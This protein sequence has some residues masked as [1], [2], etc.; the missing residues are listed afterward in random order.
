VTRRGLAIAVVLLLTLTAVSGAQAA[1]PPTPS[2]LKVTLAPSY[3][4]TPDHGVTV[5]WDAPVGPWAFEVFRATDSAYSQRATV[6]SLS[7][8]TEFSDSAPDVA[9]G[10]RLCYQ[11]RSQDP[12][13]SSSPKTAPVCASSE[14]PLPQPNETKSTG[15]SWSSFLTRLQDGEVAAL[16]CGTHRGAVVVRRSNVTIQSAAPRCATVTGGQFSV[17]GANVTVQSLRFNQ[18]KVK[19]KDEHASGTGNRWLRNSFTNEFT[20]I[21][22]LLG[23]GAGVCTD[24]EVAD[25][26]FYRIGNPRESNIFDHAIYLQDTVRARVHHNT[27]RQVVG[28][29]AFH[30]YP[31]TRDGLFERNATWNSY[32]GVVAGSTTTNNLARRSAFANFRLNAR[33]HPT[34][35]ASSPVG[36]G[37]GVTDNVVWNADPDYPQD[38]IDPWS[39]TVAG[40]LVENPLFRNPPGGDMTVR[41]SALTFLPGQ[42]GARIGLVPVSST[43]P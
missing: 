37:N 33:R 41:E 20:G 31:N 30:A 25:N 28:G 39:L 17:E 42:P 6:P 4:D 13:G 29:Y 18:R 16:A 5:A 1:D 11:V 10:E 14:P 34:W 38:G 19:G 26:D 32:G 8:H 22:L 36:A 43:S 15:Q 12:L 9:C 35:R 24:C 40:N 2:G 21:A 7:S 23:G 27:F 3:C